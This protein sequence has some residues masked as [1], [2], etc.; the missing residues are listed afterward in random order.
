[1]QVTSTYRFA[2]IS[3]FKARE[4]TREI[5][6]RSASDALDVLAF[7][8]KKAALLVRKT[9]KSAIANAENNADLRVDNLLVKEAV[10]GEGPTFKRFRPRARGGASPIRKRTSHIRIVL[11]DELAAQ[12]SERAAKRAARSGHRAR[13]PASAAARQNGRP[14]A[15]A[16]AVPQNEQP[17]PPPEEPAEPASP[18]T[19]PEVTPAAAEEASPPAAVS[20]GPADS[21]PTPTSNPGAE[22]AK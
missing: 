18:A 13:R 15:T 7:S 14:A 11:T 19:S 4:V 1:M 5:Q 22:E 12:A 2:R 3:A 21:T 6:G 16:A 10:V 8:P 17:A 9:L 20:G